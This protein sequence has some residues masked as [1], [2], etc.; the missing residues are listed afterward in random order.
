LP[1]DKPAP[2]PLT[3]PQ[4]PISYGAD[5]TGVSDSTSAFNSAAA[6]GDLD[7]PAGTYLLQA[8][9]SLGSRNM[10]CESGVVLNQPTLA[11]NRAMFQ[12]DGSGSVFNCNF[13]GP[14]YNVNGAGY[15]DFFEDFLH[16][17]PPST[18]YRIIGNTFNGSGGY[19]GAIDVYASDA[20]QPPPT[21]GIIGWNTFSHCDYYAVQLTSGTNF[22]IEN[23]TNQD[24]AGYIEADSTGQANTG[25]IVIGNHLTFT[26]GTGWANSVA[27]S[28]GNELTCGTDAGNSPFDYSGN[29]CQNNI[30][31][32]T[33][34]SMIA[35]EPVRGGVAAK[36]IGN[37]CTGA[38][39]V[40]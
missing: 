25:N 28:W 21:N 11:A 3:N 13:Q 23:N 14:Y 26:Y 6:A 5:P 16:L 32:G 24:C 29:I 22:T 8:G 10:R 19:S 27:R 33:A 38:C 37:T 2:P 39:T 1:T 20:Q 36:Y 30:V 31:D 17:N 15:Q 34:S 7:V 18:G 35:I 40:N 12:I 4:N 9:G